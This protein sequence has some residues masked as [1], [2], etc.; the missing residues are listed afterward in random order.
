M[1]YSKK[2]RF[3]TIN[4]YESH[5]RRLNLFKHLPSITNNGIVAT[6]L[7]FFE[8]NEKATKQVIDMLTSLDSPYNTQR[9]KFKRIKEKTQ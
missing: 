2:E 9:G 1:N 3:V 4:I 5:W 6:M 8:N 7:D